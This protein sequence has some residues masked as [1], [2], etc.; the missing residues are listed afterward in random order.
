MRSSV[1]FREVAEVPSRA[2]R[3]PCGCVDLL[4]LARPRQCPR[5]T[6]PPGRAGGSSSRSVEAT[7]FWTICVGAAWPSSNTATVGIGSSADRGSPKP[8][9]RGTAISSCFALP[10]TSS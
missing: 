1:T 6:H 5:R 2:G 8:S 4:K 3:A 10:D 7:P 9:G